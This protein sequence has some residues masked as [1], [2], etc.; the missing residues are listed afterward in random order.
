M[1]TTVQLCVIYSLQQKTLSLTNCH[2]SAVTSAIKC[3]LQGIL[4]LVSL[5]KS[6]HYMGPLEVALRLC[7]AFQLD[8]N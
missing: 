2:V 7:G 6:G 8:I 4:P 5:M 1:C 3:M